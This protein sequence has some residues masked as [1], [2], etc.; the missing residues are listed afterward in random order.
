MMMVMVHD[1]AEDGYGEH[2]HVGDGDDDDDFD[3][4]DS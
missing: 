4:D 3:V 2:D 1:G